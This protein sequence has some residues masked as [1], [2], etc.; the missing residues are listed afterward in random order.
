MQISTRPAI[1]IKDRSAFSFQWKK[2][3]FVL[4]F[5]MSSTVAVFGSHFRYGVMT[6]TRLSETPTTVTYKVTLSTSWNL[7]WNFGTTTPSHSIVRSGGNTGSFT[8]TGPLVL[9]PSGQWRNHIAT[10]TVVLNKSA[11][12]TRLSFASNAKIST[13]S[14]NANQP[15]DVYCILNTNAPGNPP[16]SNMPAIINMPIGAPAAT[17]AVPVS[18]PDAGTTFT[19]G[20]PSFT[21]NLLNSS[22]PAGFSIT[23][24]GLITFNT[25]G[26]LIGQQY[27]AMITVKD[28]DGNTIFLDFLIN[29]VGPSNPPAFDYSVTPTN[30]TEFN[31]IAG[32]TLNFGIKATDPDINSTVSLSV[33]GLNSA[34]S[35]ANFSANPLPATG[36]PAIT[37]FSY[38]PNG[39]AIGSSTVLNF[40]ATDNVG[41]Q[42][43]T[44]V[45]I[46]V[47]AEPAPVFVA[48]TPVLNS[49]RQILTGVLLQDQIVASSS[50][51]SN[52]SIA[53]A[54]IPA[55][56][57][58]S[59][60]VPTVGANPA[61]TT[62]SW[63]PTPANWGLHNLNFQAVISNIPSIFTQ[64]NYQIEVNTPPVF[65][66]TPPASLTVMAGQPFTYNIVATDPDIPFGDH[67]DII[68]ATK[69]AWLTLTQ[70]SPTTAVLTG[71]PTA[72]DAG[73]N[74]VHL[75]LE[76][77]YHHGN[78][79]HVEQEF[80]ITVIAGVAP[81]IVVPASIVSC[82]PVVNFAATETVGIPASTITYSIAPGSTFPVG[83]TT[84]TATASNTL[85]TSTKTFTVTVSKPIADIA[86]NGAT[87]FCEG[88]NV[89]LSAAPYALRF[90]GSQ[91]VN[92]P[93]GFPATDDITIEA[94]VTPTVLADGTF[95]VIMNHNSWYTGT[96]H[97]QF[98]PDG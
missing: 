16:V 79:S 9:D 77:I 91:H 69:P 26:K 21:G 36:N 60:A 8:V 27:N 61:T 96:I 30:G 34:I 70:T 88:S 97:F 10:A 2:S 24:A 7:A 45:T 48:P 5:L 13:I 18:D 78:P 68:A 31:V 75:E 6:A 39:A 37:S 56:A 19:F 82:D 84:V 85:G 43:S 83:T 51:G 89:P 86:V 67:L 12:P 14:N 47:V 41:V 1:P 54:T 92:V 20:T 53:F 38:T 62:L 57:T 93:N 29:M 28:N 59:P 32:Q 72:A 58:L 44:S 80:T 71:T 95:K 98:F 46:K 52:V 64:H 73:A 4:F 90:N 22:N 23:P 76:D 74:T 65:A 55:G 94:T 50:L 33:A 42:S 63:T 11:T 17:Y 15:W 3:L 40:S 66:S 25:V 35:L 87:T 81:S 49:A